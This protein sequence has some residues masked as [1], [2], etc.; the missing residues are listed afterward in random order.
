MLNALAAAMPLQ[1]PAPNDKLSLAMDATDTHNGGVIQQKSGDYWRPL[2][3]FSHK[4]TDTES[5]YSPF[6]RELLAGHATNKHFR[7]FCE[8]QAFQLWTDHNPLV[9]AI[10]WRL[11]ASAEQCSTGPAYPA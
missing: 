4:L 1:H 11:F 5:H 7:H 8:G 2:G 6:D 3:F 10:S 9:T